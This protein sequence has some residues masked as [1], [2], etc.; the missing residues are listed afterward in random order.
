MLAAASFNGSSG[1]SSLGA[2]S[3]AKPGAASALA[4]VQKALGVSV[5]DIIDAVSGP[6]I[7][8]VKAGAPLPEVTLVVKPADAQKAQQ[9]V[10]AL[11]GKLAK[12]AKPTS[13]TVNGVTLQSVSLGPVSIYYGTFDGQLVLTDSQT[14]IGE[15]QSKSNRL[16]DDDTFK[17]AQKAAGLPDSAS[18]WLYVDLQDTIPA[19]EG[20]AT[21]AGQQVPPA[22]S[23]NLQPLKSFV[24]YGSADGDTTTAVV[25]LQTK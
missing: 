25:F 3:L 1:L 2:S 6:G 15:L 9:T 8:Y 5:Q 19:V 14:A 18:A 17:A 10:G 20:L 23:P 11:I 13:T 16:A 12:G 24:A 22:V 21:L 7:L 4:Q